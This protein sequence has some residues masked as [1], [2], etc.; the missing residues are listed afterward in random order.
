MSQPFN[1]WKCGAALA[2][3]LPLSRREECPHCGADLHCCRFCREFDPGV[4]GQCR[5]ERAEEV[6]DKTRANFCDYLRPDP[7]AQRP[8]ARSDAERARAE[9][10]ELFGDAPASPAAA[11]PS[12]APPSEAE[13]ALAELRRLF[14]D[15]PD[16]PGETD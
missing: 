4:A 1:C 14:G 13:R 3:L 7:D 11:Q 6:N 9:L 8:A 16:K 12:D 5:E 15:A 10:A 2:L